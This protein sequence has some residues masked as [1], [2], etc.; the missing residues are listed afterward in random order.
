MR[1]A[2]NKGYVDCANGA[3]R[4]LLWVLFGGSVVAATIYDVSQWIV[5]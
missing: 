5:W 3:A 1:L 2:L 4:G